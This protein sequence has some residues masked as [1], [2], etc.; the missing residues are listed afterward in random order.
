ME[1]IKL[2]QEIEALI[3]SLPTGTTL[4]AQDTAA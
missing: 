1:M 3:T 4:D 2:A